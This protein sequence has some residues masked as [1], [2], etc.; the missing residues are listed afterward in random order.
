MVQAECIYKS[1]T[2]PGPDSLAW[3]LGI[4]AKHPFILADQCHC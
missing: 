4:P 1:L 2:I 3:K